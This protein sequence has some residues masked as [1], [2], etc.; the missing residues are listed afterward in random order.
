MMNLVNKQQINKF[1]EAEVLS[2]YGKVCDQ[3]YDDWYEAK[4]DFLF[5]YFQDTLIFKKKVSLQKSYDDLMENCRPMYD[6]ITN[7]MYKVFEWSEFSGFKDIISVGALAQNK[8]LVEKELVSAATGKPVKIQVGTKMSRA[9]KHLVSPV[10]L[11][12]LQVEYSKVFN[13]KTFNGYL[14]LSI[15]PLD[16][17][18]MSVN[19]SGWQS[20]LNAYDGCYRAGIGAL[21][22][23]KN[24]MIGYFT[25][26]EEGVQLTD[27]LKWNDKKWRTIIS[28]K[29]G[30]FVHLN[31]QY[32]YKT[33][34]LSEALLDF[35]QEIFFEGMDMTPT[36][37][38]SEYHISVDV[39]Y[40][41]MYNDAIYR[42]TEV[43]VVYHSDA[44]NEFHT[45]ITICG[46][47]TCP[48]CGEKKT[49]FS[50]HL[51]C[52]DCGDYEVC[53]DCGRPIDTTDDDVIYLDDGGVYVCYEC[54]DNYSWCDHCDRYVP[55]DEINDYGRWDRIC[56]DCVENDPHIVQCENCN[57]YDDE[58]RMILK[59]VD[60]T[61]EDAGYQYFCPDCAD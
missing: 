42:P 6:K 31:R 48:V 4:S 13:D 46:S 32:P 44:A 43:R 19:G 10:D 7:S 21:M 28:I 52:V 26:N 49:E 25:T 3:F 27:E 40:D 58:D 5:D 51:E 47:S 11:E 24:T 39:D 38:K 1:L 57:R 30:Q 29:D 16:Y 61:D 15:H 50:R 41:L 54:A 2:N 14:C 59:P 17:I 45:G 37:N 34:I 36:V 18:T 8:V 55:Y 20:C 33:D 56:N 22:N 9:L 53:A 23:S 60:V 35:A 12:E